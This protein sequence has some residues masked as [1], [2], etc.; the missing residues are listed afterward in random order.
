PQPLA[1]R[2]RAQAVS[3][4]PTSPTLVGRARAKVRGTADDLVAARRTMRGGRLS[5]AAHLVHERASLLHSP[6]S[7]RPAEVRTGTGTSIRYR[8]N[9]GDVRSL[10]EVWFEDVYR[11]PEHWRPRT[12]LD[13]G[14]N[15]GLTSLWFHQRWPEARFVL[16]E[17]DPA[18]VVLARRNLDTNGV[19]GMV[20]AAAV[21]PEAGSARFASDAA[22][23]L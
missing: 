1:R 10:R 12:V 8:A 14:A 4:S 13:L 23:N 17:P 15:I 11:L 18:N 7:G 9:P 21:G 5:L 6:W 16:V 20:L 3:G 22:S 2:R 19:L